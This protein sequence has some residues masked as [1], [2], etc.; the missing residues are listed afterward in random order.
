MLPRPERSLTSTRWRLPTVSGCDVLVGG[1]ILQ[2]GADVHAALVREGALAD[3]RLVVAQRQVGQFGDEAAD[4]GEAGQL[5]GADGGVA[6]LQF[7]VGDDGGQVGVAAALAVAVHA[8]LHV[9]GAGF[10]G[11]DGVGH[12]HVGIVMRVD[13]DDAVEALAHFGDDLRP[14]GR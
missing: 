11:G 5:L 6:Q 2:H 12:G 14:G 9:R 13:A 8:A 10:H 3:E 7:Q 1:G 4:R